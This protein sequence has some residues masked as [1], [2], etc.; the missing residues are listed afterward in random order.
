MPI[1]NCRRLECKWGKHKSR[2]NYMTF[3]VL[4]N[5]LHIIYIYKMFGAKSL[6]T[7]LTCT[8]VVSH[9]TMIV[10][11]MKK[12]VSR[13]DVTIL[14]AIISVCKDQL[15][16]HENPQLGALIVRLDISVCVLRLL[17]KMYIILGMFTTPV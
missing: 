8:C 16:N 1:V 9:A 6:T 7:L 12:F 5:T 14:N 15:Q 13:S 10:N 2:H 17:N 3:S 4:S 11:C